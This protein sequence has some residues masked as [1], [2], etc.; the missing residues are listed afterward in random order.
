MNNTGTIDLQDRLH[1][2]HV[3]ATSIEDAC[4]VQQYWNSGPN[5]RFSKNAVIFLAW[6]L[7]STTA[8]SDPFV[9]ERIHHERAVTVCYCQETIGRAISRSEALRI[10]LQ[11]LEQAERERLEYAHFEAEKGISWSDEK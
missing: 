9:K 5:A 1:E 4:H 3:P 8:I 10:S 6:F 7:S 2:T 11:I